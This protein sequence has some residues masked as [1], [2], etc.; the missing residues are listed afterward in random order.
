[1][2]T[3][4]KRW[5]E[6]D[7]DFAARQLWESFHD[8]ILYSNRFFIKHPLLELL[9]NYIKDNVIT[10]P[11]GSLFYRAR[12]IDDKAWKDHMLYKCEVA[13]GDEKLNVDYFRKANRF[14]GLTKSASFVPPEGVIV[15]EGRSNP[16]Y[17]KYLYVS[18]EPTTA[19]FEV[20]PLLTDAINLAKIVVNSE[21]KIANI[22]FD[23]ND[24]S[25]KE[26]TKEMQVM[27]CI[28]AAFSK[29]T[30]NVEDYLPTQII[31]EYVKNLGYEGIRYNSSLYRK[32][33][34]YT[35]FAYDK[36]EAITSQEF[37]IEDFKITASAAITSV[38]Y[39]GDLRY[40]VDNEPKYLH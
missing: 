18:E 34:N 19:L 4:D 31:A 2:I 21:L 12:I 26:R 11:A 36:C 5:D 13:T 1:M 39:D 27:R 6:T 7:E 38:S 40:I 29:P 17:I 22:S 16:K 10:I 20:R 25:Q 3:V 8:S 14:R 23:N 35:I 28:Q 15:G 33:I 9:K 30:N 32:G 37:R 24:S